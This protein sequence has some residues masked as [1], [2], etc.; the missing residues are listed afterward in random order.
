MAQPTA[1]WRKH[2]ALARQDAQ[3]EQQLQRLYRVSVWLRW[4]IAAALWLIVAPLCLWQL[5]SDIALWRD[6]F[7]W[8]A[9]RFG[10]AYNRW[11]AIGLALC[12]GCTVGNL[13][14]QSQIILFGPTQ[15]QARQFE[16]QL[17]TIRQMGDRHPLWKWVCKPQK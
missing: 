12:I 10:L 15:F 8:T 14:R 4:A 11:A 2:S 6:T 3:F 5:R 17:Q 9:V 16:Q 7:T 13:L 1:N